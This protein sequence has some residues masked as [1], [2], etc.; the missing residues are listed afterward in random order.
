MTAAKRYRV[1][2]FNLVLVVLVVYFGYLVIGQYFELIAV[3]REAE[4]VQQQL[5]QARQ[6]AQQLQVERERLQSPDY[7]EK[8]AREELGLVK[9]GEAPVLPPKTQ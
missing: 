9:P 4:M 8:L 6:K 5:E 3:R 1:N 7:I 2:W